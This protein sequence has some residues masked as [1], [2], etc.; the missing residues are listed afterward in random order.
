M[1]KLFNFQ[2]IRAKMIFGFLV[3]LVLVIGLSIYNYTTL[4]N[5]NDTTEEVL[6]VEL[7]V[8]IA[9]EQLI[10]AMF[11]RMGA[12][13][14]YIISGDKQ[15][16]EIFDT[17]SADVS[18]QQDVV[19]KLA[20]SKNFSHE[21]FDELIGN[22]LEWE[23]FIVETVF[24][25]YDKGNEDVA[26]D[27]LILAEGYVGSLVDSYTDLVTDTENH[28]IKLEEEILANG[29]TTTTIVVVVSIAV[30]LFSLVVAIVTS[31]SISRPIKL[32]MQRMGVISEGDLS[33]E[34][35]KTEL[36]DETGQLVASTNEMNAT[37]RDLLDQINT[38]S[39]TVNNQ[40]DELTQSANEVRAGTEQIS[41]TMEEL[42]TGAESQAN[43]ATDLTSAM[44]SF[45]LKVEEADRDGEHVQEASANVLNMTEEGSGLMKSSTKQMQSIDRIVQDAVTKVEGLDTHAQEISE[46]VS[47]IRDIADQTNLLALNAA[48]E[49]ARAGEH[50]QG[51]AVVADE[52]RKLA[53]Q[54]STSVMNI[55]EIVDNI[56]SESSIVA[57]SL[58]DSYKEV[59]S[60]TE[61]IITTGETFANIQSATTEMAQ[62]IQRVSNNLADISENSQIMNDSIQDIAAVSEQAAAGVEETTASAQQT[63]SAMEEVAGN[64][65]ELAQLAE[66][67]NELVGRFKL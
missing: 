17:V 19:A 24:D 62:N 6:D 60:G 42:A 13:R 53:E 40:S 7:P 33:Q 66:R 43:T 58:R 16:R 3:V 59:E 50:G 30:I 56:Q 21:E 12:A 67:L 55:T 32:V 20:S 61:Q 49:A 26:R 18:K 39:E 52:V 47:V 2:T 36:N 54:S 57:D 27:N 63:T 46:L 4:K 15:Y 31:N 5:V 38:V 48:I 22:T 35:L 41:M 14:A 44:S 8:L 9:E 37:M 28:I 25:E 65:V 34:P 10:S 11:N 64:S 29:K 51:F 45:T 1:K 23:E